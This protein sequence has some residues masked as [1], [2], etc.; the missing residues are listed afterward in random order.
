MPQV[1]NGKNIMLVEV[2]MTTRWY[3]TVALP[4]LSKDTAVYR[5][6]YEQLLNGRLRIANDDELEILQPDR[7]LFFDTYNQA[8][9][10]AS[11][12]T[13]EFGYFTQVSEYVT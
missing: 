13:A 2:T 10:V 9:E 8:E 6:L 12:L 7:I 11:K 4:N 1:R 5:P 3:I